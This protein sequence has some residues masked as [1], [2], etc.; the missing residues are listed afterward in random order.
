MIIGISIFFAC[1]VAVFGIIAVHEYGHYLAG[2][3]SGIPRSAMSVRLF[4]FPQHVA[5]RSENRWLHPQRD[6]ERYVAA[7]MALLKSRN[8]AGF[9]VAGGLLVQTLAFV[10]LVFSMAAAGVPRFVLSPVVFALVSVPCLYL[11]F[12]LLS[13][14]F[15]KKPS[16][17]FSFLWRISPVASCVLTLFV[18]GAHVGVLLHVLKT[19]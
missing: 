11:L 10:A 3:S 6:Y 14:H 1:V 9:Y 17:D 5:L 8:R 7:S 18:F 4:V 2:A 19:A 12:D 15:K 16:G 13:S